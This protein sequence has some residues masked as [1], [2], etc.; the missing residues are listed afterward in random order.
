[1][2]NIK[3]KDNC[4]LCNGGNL[5]EVFRLTD[6]PLANAFVTKND[7]EKHQEEY[8]LRLN[9]CRDCTHVQLSHVVDPEILY[10]H[11][12]YVS[13]TSPV[14]VKHFQSYVDSLCSDY[15]LKNDSLVVEFGSND[16]TMMKFFKEKGMRVLGIDPAEEITINASHNGLE[17]FNGYFNAITAE[18]IRIKYGQADAIIANNVMA[19]IDDLDDVMSGVSS[20]LKA[21]GFFAFEFSYIVDVIEK[22]LFDTIYHEHLDYHSVTPLVKFFTKHG[23]K[24]ISSKRVDTH[25]G[26]VRMVVQKNGG[27]LQDDG[28]T[29]VL[30][31]LEKKLDLDNENTLISFANAVEKIKCKLS[32]CLKNIKDSGK[33]LVIFGAP[34]KATTLMYHFSIKADDIKY[35]VDDS[36]LKQGLYSPG[37]HIPIAPSE[38]LYVN[39]PD[40]VLI[41]AWNFATPIINNHKKL[42]ELGTR[43]IVPL[44]KIEFIPE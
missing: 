29:K 20:L 11:Y 31:S 34:A 15:K 3:S 13:G 24:V 25:G 9:F 19:H 22:H 32:T 23:F 2:L 33:T 41:L 7:K 36:P 4:R 40:I 5:K 26:S 35:I 27:N 37:K 30:L 21:N 38:E 12:L 6:S 16:G 39:R 28:S 1:M 44:P 18:D 42:I 14:F 17:T 10:K 8:P 43:F